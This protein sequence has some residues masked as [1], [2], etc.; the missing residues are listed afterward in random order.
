VEHRDPEVV[1]MLEL[2]IS[3]PERIEGR[4]VDPVLRIDT[5]DADQQHALG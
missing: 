3:L 4:D 1:V 5:I 2:V